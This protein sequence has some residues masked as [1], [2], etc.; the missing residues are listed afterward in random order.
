MMAQGIY[1]ASPTEVIYDFLVA[2]ALPCN[3]PSTDRL[4]F[5]MVNFWLNGPHI[6]PHPA[7]PQ[8]QPL[9]QVKHCANLCRSHNLFLCY[10]IP[11]EPPSRHTRKIS[12][13]AKIDMAIAA[14]IQNYLGKPGHHRKPYEYAIAPCTRISQTAS[15]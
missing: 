3:H 6:P 5:I 7:L 12:K 11:N 14:P 13:P 2:V 8:P 4:P 10:N 1:I 15:A 9:A